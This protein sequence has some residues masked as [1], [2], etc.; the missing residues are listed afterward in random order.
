M[1][2][3]LDDKI[4]YIKGQIERLVDETAYL[5]G[6]AIDHNSVKDADILIVRT[7]T[8]CDRRLLEDTKVKLIVTATIGFDHIDTAY[9]KHAGIQWANCPGCN[10]NSVCIY[11]HNALIATNKLRPSMTIG[12]IGVGHVGTL[13]LNDLEQQG[14]NVLLSDPPR[15]D[16]GDFIE[17]HSFTNIKTIQEQADIITFHT[18]LTN[19]GKYPTYHLADRQFFQHLKRHPLIIN[20]SRGGVVDNEALYDALTEGTVSDAVID[21]WENEPHINTKLLQRVAIG[22]PH[23]AGY[24]ADGKANATRMALQVVA[25]YLATP[26]T[27]N[28]HIPQG[29]KLSVET[30]MKDSRS[31]KNAPDLFEE[32]RS[33]YP[34]R[35]E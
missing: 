17:G 20:A 34:I 31:L 8:H 22:T 24:S 9:C 2:V 5:P 18:P 33:D 16:T 11:V 28:I 12:I 1:K 27:A 35:R 6:S 26:F 7:R 3:V 4:P 29:E 32:F 14:M 15:E 10:A 19:E 23:I 21:T 30:L 25:D 13:I